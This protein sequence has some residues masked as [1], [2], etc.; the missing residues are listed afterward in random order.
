MTEQN[1]HPH[2]DT[3][4]RVHI[5]VNGIVENYVELKRRLVDM[6]ADF[7]SETDAEVIAHL[8]AHHCAEGDLLD[9]V[10]AAYAELRGHYAFVAMSA[11]RARRARR[12]AQGVPADHR[13]RRRRAVH[14]LRDP[15]VPRAHP[16]AFSSSTTTRSSC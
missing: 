13:P 11:R 14:R 6:G 12:R 3:T 4:D 5:V 1:A 9:A 7:T 16:R 15:G 2:Y 10:R 8:V